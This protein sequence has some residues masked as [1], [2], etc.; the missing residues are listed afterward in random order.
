MRRQWTTASGTRQAWRSGGRLL[1]DAQLLRLSEAGLDT[2]DRLLEVET[3]ELAEVAGVDEATAS[4]LQATVREQVDAAARAVRT[5][6][7]D[8][9]DE[10]DKT[11]ETDETGDASMTAPAGTTPEAPADAPGE[12]PTAE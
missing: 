9:T 8:E 3:A 6:E 10:T 7:T 11:D 12:T 4:E 2:A 1:D 5:D